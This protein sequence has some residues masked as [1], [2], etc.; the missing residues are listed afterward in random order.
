[1]N[2]PKNRKRP[3]PVIRFWSKVNKDGPIHPYNPELGNCWEWTAATTNGYGRYRIEGKANLATRVAWEMKH[4][5]IPPG[6]NVL[7]SCDNPPCIRH[8]FLGTHA[9]NMR[10]AKIKGRMR[11]AP[12]I[13]EKHWKSR[14]S[15][16]Q[17]FEIR[18]VYINGHG[19]STNSY[20]LSE[21]YGVTPSHIREIVRGASWS[22]LNGIAA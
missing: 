13:G 2:Y 5:P 19:S 3:D 21:K 8:L 6:L 10:D 4:G 14:L 7:H 11:T 16:S 12:Q 15:E 18:R 17:I 1:M 22:H 20:R 9:E